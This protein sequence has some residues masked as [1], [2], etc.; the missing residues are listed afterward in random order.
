[1]ED[2]VPAV[3]GLTYSQNPVG[4]A[5]QAIGGIQTSGAFNN[6]Q[7]LVAPICRPMLNNGEHPMRIAWI[8]ASSVGS[9]IQPLNG[10][11]GRGEHREVLDAI[12][13]E[14]LVYQ[15]VQ[16]RPHY[17]GAKPESGRSHE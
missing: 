10:S 5:V 8:L 11:Y 7:S 4:Q 16:P 1:M 2:V 12:D 3:P 15:A 17:T 6:T 13:A 14:R 9:P